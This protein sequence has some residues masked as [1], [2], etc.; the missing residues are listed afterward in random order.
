MPLLPQKIPRGE[1]TNSTLNIRPALEGS[2]T[3]LFSSSFYDLRF[4]TK[5]PD[6]Q[7]SLDQVPPIKLA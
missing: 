4:P 5:G 2:L 7:I 6:C 1:T 3:S